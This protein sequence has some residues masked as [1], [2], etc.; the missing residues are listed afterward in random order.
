MAGIRSKF[1][2]S[3]LCVI[4]VVRV[5]GIAPSSILVESQID[6]MIAILRVMTPL[7]DAIGHL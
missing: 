1:W 5:A 6:V 2:E 3:M 4:G 7:F